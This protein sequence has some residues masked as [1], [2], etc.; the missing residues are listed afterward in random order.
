MKKLSLLNDLVTLVKNPLTIF[1][2]VYLLGCSIGYYICFY[3]STILAF[4]FFV[5]GGYFFVIAIIFLFGSHV[6]YYFGFIICFEI[7]KDKPITSV[8]F[9]DCFGYLGSLEI[10]I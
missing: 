5:L 9:Q 6:V 7:R 3:A 10:S 8:L 4:G 2:K 1:A